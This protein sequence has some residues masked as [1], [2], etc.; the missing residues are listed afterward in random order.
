MGQ[1]CGNRTC[2]PLGV[3]LILIAVARQGQEPCG[4]EMWQQDLLGADCGD[5]TPPRATFLSLFCGCVLVAFLLPFSLLPVL[6]RTI[7][8]CRAKAVTFPCHFLYMPPLSLFIVLNLGPCPHAMITCWPSL[9]DSCRCCLIHDCYPCPLCWLCKQPLAR[10]ASQ[11]TD[12]CGQTGG[13]E[14]CGAEMWQQDLLPAGCGVDTDSCSPTRTGAMWGRDVAT[15]P[16][17]GR[18]WRLDSA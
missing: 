2:C 16:P 15:G 5:L 9:L 18:L 14:P 4:A 12:S 6:P 1:R 3:A 10:I 7:T 8:A 17:W 13:Q 11:D